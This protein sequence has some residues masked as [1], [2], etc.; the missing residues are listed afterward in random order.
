MERYISNLKV[1]DK[2]RKKNTSC[3][4]DFLCFDL[5]NLSELMC[6]LMIKIKNY[7]LT[8]YY[9]SDMLW[10]TLSLCCGMSSVW[11]PAALRALSPALRETASSTGWRV[12]LQ[13]TSEDTVWMGVVWTWS[14]NQARTSAITL[15]GGSTVMEKS[16]DL[17]CIA[18][19][20]RVNY[21]NPLLQLTLTSQTYKSRIA[22]LHSAPLYSPLCLW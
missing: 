11:N 4:K 18:A 7:S 15:M 8:I 10:L 14:P 12:G 5:I 6:L 19:S 13:S 22:G 9:I 2:N 21:Q 16:L 3:F 1:K 17:R 20:G